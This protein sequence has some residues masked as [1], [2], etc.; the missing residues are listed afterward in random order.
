MFDTTILSQLHCRIIF[1]G[2]PSTC[3]PFCVFL[4]QEAICLTR[5]LIQTGSTHIV[6]SQQLSCVTHQSFANC[7][8]WGTA[9]NA[10][11]QMAGRPRHPNVDI[12]CTRNVDNPHSYSMSCVLEWTQRG[13][14]C[15]LSISRTLNGRKFLRSKN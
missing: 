10:T 11:S 1:T 7:T 5:G 2:C 14:G 4:P 3:L 6:H 9:H 8:V 13:E 15:K 12:E